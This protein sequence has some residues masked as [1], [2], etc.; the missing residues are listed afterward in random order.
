[1]GAMSTFLV[2]VAVERWDAR[3]VAAT[4]G[5]V[6]IAYAVIWGAAVLISRYRHAAA[7]TETAGEATVDAEAAWT[8]PLT[9][10]VPL[11]GE[12]EMLP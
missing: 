5:V 9:P 1:M 7:W 3:T 8:D 2:G 11:E 12:H 10:G 6:F 4:M